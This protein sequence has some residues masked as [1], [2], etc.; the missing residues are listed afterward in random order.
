MRAVSAYS[1][2]NAGLPLTLVRSSPIV[3][4]DDASA[5]SLIP[6]GREL[7]E[8]V[9]LLDTSV[10]DAGVSVPLACALSWPLTR[11]TA[12]VLKRFSADG[13]SERRESCRVSCFFCGGS[14]A[15]FEGVTRP[16]VG[17][18]SS[19]NASEATDDAGLLE[20]AA[21]DEDASLGWDFAEPEP[22]RE[23]A[24]GRDV[25]LR[26]GCRANIVDVCMKAGCGHDT[27]DMA[28]NPLG[29]DVL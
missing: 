24:E 19:F 8:A 3:F 21:E 9:G 4:E 20:T 27:R 13:L 16:F 11:L 26:V 15:A 22:K 17:V 7:T 1:T 14:V 25:V 12:L 29:C 5:D 28:H 6:R 10:P 23:R 2:R 18:G